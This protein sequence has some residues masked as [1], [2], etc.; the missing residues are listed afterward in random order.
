MNY[1]YSTEILYLALYLS[2][3]KRVNCQ[4]WIF[5]YQN[6]IMVFSFDFGSDRADEE[7]KKIDSLGGER[8]SDISWKTAEEIF[9]EDSHLCALGMTSLLV[10]D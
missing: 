5:A 10:A 7:H 9:L 2:E 1:K 6:T 3:I 4:P 8:P